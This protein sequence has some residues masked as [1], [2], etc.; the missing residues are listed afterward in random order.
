MKPMVRAT[1]AEAVFD[2]DPEYKKGKPS[3]ISFFNSE[4]QQEYSFM[5]HK[6]RLSTKQKT[7][8]FDD[9][10]LRPEEEND[11]RDSNAMKF[12]H[13][14]SKK[15]SGMS[16]KQKAEKEDDDKEYAAE[17]VRHELKENEQEQIPDLLCIMGIEI[18]DRIDYEKKVIKNM[19]I[20]YFLFFIFHFFIFHFF[21]FL[22]PFFDISWFKELK[23]WKS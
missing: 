18:T 17:Y 9:E 1:T 20:F 8:R 3:E 11:R 15:D 12:W 23:N 14:S 10:K 5:V 22:S 2:Y 16:S 7:V 21:F 19:V 13:Q 6:F 4:K